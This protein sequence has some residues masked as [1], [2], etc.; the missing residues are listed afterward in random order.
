MNSSREE[1]SV[2]NVSHFRAKVL[3]VY[4]HFDFSLTVFKALERRLNTIMSMRVM[5]APIEYD[6]GNYRIADSARQT[7]DCRL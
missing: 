7:A 6:L 3:G 4:R 1:E 2:S 5:N